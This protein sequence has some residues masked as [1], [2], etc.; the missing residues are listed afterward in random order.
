MAFAVNKYVNQM[1]FTPSFWRST[2]SSSREAQLSPFARGFRLLWARCSDSFCAFN[3]NWVALTVR[4]A[5]KT[6]RPQGR[7][8][9]KP[10]K[11]INKRA[12]DH[13]ILS[14]SCS[15]VAAAS[16]PARALA[17]TRSQSLFRREASQ[18]RHSNT[19]R[20][21]AATTASQNTIHHRAP[22]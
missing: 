1:E 9:T 18:Q 10:S 3:L 15:V 6:T 20:H 13:L 16:F 5:K 21:P 12:G 14:H 4:L 19:R 17:C 2:A 22:A 7:H 8:P 11:N